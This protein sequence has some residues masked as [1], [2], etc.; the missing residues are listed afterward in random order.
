[1]GLFDRVAQAHGEGR[2]NAG[3]APS[4]E[5]KQET[6][7]GVLSG[8]NSPDAPTEAQIEAYAAEKEA[9]K[10]AEKSALAEAKAAAK[11][12]ASKKS[13]A[14]L[15]PLFED[16]NNAEAYEEDESELAA[17]LAELREDERNAEKPQEEKQ[18]DSL[19]EERDLVGKSDSS[20]FDN[21]LSA[22][23]R[24]VDSAASEGWAG[25]AKEMGLNEKSSPLVGRKL[26]DIFAAEEKVRGIAKEGIRGLNRKDELDTPEAIYGEKDRRYEPWILFINCQPSSSE[27]VRDFGEWVQQ[28]VDKVLE[29]HSAK[30]YMLPPLDNGKGSALIEEMLSRYIQA[31]PEKMPK[32]MTVDRNHPLYSVCCA[33]VKPHYRKNG[34]VVEGF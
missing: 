21:D 34:N 32:G 12:A 28:F 8:I 25:L 27:G 29:K 31:R 10:E 19:V 20:A 3:K 14:A 7:D 15:A 22:F 24:V 33:T 1:M 13:R 6:G 16:E 5:A 9:A 30:H 26:S 2:D 18:T 11:A 17:I 4:I 23:A